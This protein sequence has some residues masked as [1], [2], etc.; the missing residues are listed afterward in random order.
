MVPCKFH[1]PRDKFIV[2]REE[3][4][5]SGKM[6]FGCVEGTE[7]EFW[8]KRKEG[9]SSSLRKVIALSCE[10]FLFHSFEGSSM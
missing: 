9:E 2:V 8:G 5:L 10:S 6:G 4:L 1:L 3:Y 7:A